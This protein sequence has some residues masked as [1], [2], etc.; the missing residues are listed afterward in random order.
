MASFTKAILSGSTDGTGISVHSATAGGVITIHTG[1]STTTTIEE[2]WLTAYN[3]TS[4]AHLITLE[5]G[6]SATKDTIK[7]EVAPFDLAPIVDGLPLQG[8]AT[9]LVISA[10]CSTT[11]AF[12]VFG[13]INRI[14]QS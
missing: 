3:G 11:D 12:S 8:N 7:K 2:V 6:A 14:D 9:P 10:Y 5:W 4:Q 1:N 13:H